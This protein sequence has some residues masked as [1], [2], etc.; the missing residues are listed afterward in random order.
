MLFIAAKQ[1]EAPDFCEIPLERIE[2]NKSLV[3]RTSL[4][5]FNDFP[6]VN[7]GLRKV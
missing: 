3:S 6:K 7:L 2:R 4:R 1:R 5:R